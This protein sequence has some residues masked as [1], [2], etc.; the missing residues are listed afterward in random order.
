MI[1]TINKIVRTQRQIMSEFGREPLLRTVKKL[2][3]PLEKV[4]KVLKMRKSRFLE[5]PVG[6]EEDS[7]L[8]ILLRIKC[9][10]TFRHCY[11]I[12]S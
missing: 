10:S 6:D 2:A 5:T 12:K 11:P 8:G 9:S 1:E 4:R 3:M 7:S